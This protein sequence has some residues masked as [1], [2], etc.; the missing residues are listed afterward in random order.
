MN[1]LDEKAISAIDADGV[2]ARA[3]TTSG[4]IGILTAGGDAPGMNAAIRAVVRAAANAEVYVF[5]FRRGYDGLIKD[6]AEP[7][8]G[9]SVANIVQRGGTFLETSRSDDFRSREGRTRAATTSRL[10]A[11]ISMPTPEPNA[12]SLRRSAEMGRATGMG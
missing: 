10:V 3:A 7:L 6:L 4:P 1:E 9:R 2:G 12:S 8:S 5:G 11:P